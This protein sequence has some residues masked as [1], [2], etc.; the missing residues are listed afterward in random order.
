MKTSFSIGNRQV[1]PGNPCF[2]VAENGNNHAGNFEHALQ[3]VDVAGKLGADAMTFQ[4][5]PIETMCATEYLD[6]A[7]FAF[8]K[9]C[10]FSVDQLATLAARARQHGMAFSVNVEDADTLAIMVEQV[11]IDFIKLCSADLTNIPYL[12]ASA[13]FELPIFFSTG[14]STIGEIEFAYHALKD[15]GVQE[16]VIYHTNSG[17][18]T[19]VSEANIRQM[20]LLQ[21][22][23]GGVKGYCDHTCHIIPPVVAVSRGACVVEKHITLS[24]A[25]KGD[26]WMVSLEEDEFRQ[27][28]GYIRDSEAALGTRE[29]RPL[30][31]EEETRA[32]K[33]KSV[34][35]KLPIKAGTVLKEEMFVYKLPGRGISPADIDRLVGRQLVVDVVEDVVLEPGM[36]EPPL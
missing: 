14:A 3:V 27:M 10:E 34:V 7:R 23:F 33:R 36:I 2:V 26:D 9:D 17:Y 16:L 6:D 28:L 5:A 19:P 25:L 22:I 32:L 8:L 30:P 24:R 21:D 13:S 20:D 35:S 29:K 18:P 1:G 31:V 11:G 12:R 4:Y 15:A